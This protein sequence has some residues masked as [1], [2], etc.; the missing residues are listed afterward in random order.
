[1]ADGGVGLGA[2]KKSR[3]LYGLE[4]AGFYDDGPG[5][6]RLHGDL[7][8]GTIDEARRFLI[9]DHEPSS[10][11]SR[12]ATTRCVVALDVQA[13]EGEQ[14]DSC[15]TSSN[16]RFPSSNVAMDFMTSSDRAI[17]VVQHTPIRNSNMGV[18]EAIAESHAPMVSRDI[19]NPS[20]DTPITD[21]L[22]YSDEHIGSLRFIQSQ[23]TED[24]EYKC[25]SLVSLDNALS[26][27]MTCRHH[28]GYNFCSLRLQIPRSTK[29]QR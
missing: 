17:E 13:P 28:F 14:S 20:K 24:P 8:A 21:Q 29:D 12:L 6:F 2:G 18:P 5:N 9:V 27:D 15:L 16:V 7:G 23:C 11:S 25:T 10:A 26:R 22:G 19:F 4:E 1:M 3:F